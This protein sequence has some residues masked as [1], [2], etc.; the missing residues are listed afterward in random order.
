MKKG[1]YRRRNTLDSHP[2]LKNPITHLRTRFD[3]LRSTAA[4]FLSKS[5]L[6]AVTRLINCSEPGKRART[7][8]I[9]AMC[10]S[11][12]DGYIVE[13]TESDDIWRSISRR[14]EWKE[15]AKI[16]RKFWRARELEVFF[17]ILI[18]FSS[19]QSVIVNRFTLAVK[20]LFHNEDC[21]HVVW[22]INLK[23]AN[24]KEWGVKEGNIW[25]FRPPPSVTYRSRCTSISITQGCPSR[26][27][28]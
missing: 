23:S 11:A 21:S 16:R 25:C 17:L 2:Q 8:P 3:S 20:I 1:T 28:V 13:S 27:L 6:A 7:A 19:S 26:V 22:V 4:S 14:W 24:D 10:A 9:A 18:E 5:I 15:L 12:A